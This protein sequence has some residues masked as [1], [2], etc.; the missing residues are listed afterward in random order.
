M[1]DY[2]HECINLH[3]CAE[4]FLIPPCTPQ[5]KPIAMQQTLNETERLEQTKPRIQLGR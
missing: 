5:P 3:G 1:I 2:T 4:F